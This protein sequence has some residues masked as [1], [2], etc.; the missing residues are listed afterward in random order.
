MCLQREGLV[1]L[2]RCPARLLP[3]ACSSRLYR[4]RPLL[5]QGEPSVFEREAAA[6][7]GKAGNHKSKMQVRRR[8]KWTGR[9]AFCQALSGM[10][11]APQQAVI[12][13]QGEP[14]TAVW[15]DQSLLRAGSQQSHHLLPRAGGRA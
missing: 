12:N 3:A 2:Q 9:S 5:P 11:V 4:T 1:C 6:L 15:P 10:R 14:V 13:Q 8:V 7:K